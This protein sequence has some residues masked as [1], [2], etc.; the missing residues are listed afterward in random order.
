MSRF[1][2]TQHDD[3]DTVILSSQEF[4]DLAESALA[5]M[6]LRADEVPLISHHLLDAA[7]CGYEFAGMPRVLALERIVRA[8]GVPGPPRLVR[9]RAGFATFDGNDNFGYVAVD[10][11][12]RWLIDAAPRH[13]FAMATVHNSLYSGRNAYF[14]ERVA[15]AGLVGFYICSSGA[16]VA[17]IG[18][19]RAVLGTNP[20][21]WGF[22][23]EPDPVVIDFA[24]SNMSWG[25]L[26]LYARLGKD[27]PAGLGVDAAGQPTVAADDVL[28]GGAVFPFG[29]HKGFGLSLAIQFIGL[30]ARANQHSATAELGPPRGYVLVAL[31]PAA[32]CD[33]TTYARLSRALVD[34]LVSQPGVRV[35]SAR[36]FAERERRRREGVPVSANVVDAVRWIGDQRTVPESASDLP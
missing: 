10:L 1:D 8:N 36:A 6:G 19:S 31:D 18:G 29:G 17:P 35:P 12:T 25:D 16:R 3:L 22:P 4:V 5:A 20:V 13:G 21:A 15:R 27:L 14:M 7:E 2:S 34:D 30:L 11:A 9:E 33:A 32:V 28:H 24:T 26:E 23:L